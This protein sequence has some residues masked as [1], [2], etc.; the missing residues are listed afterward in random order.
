MHK[1][2]LENGKFKFVESYTGLDG[3][4]H[5]VSVTKNN[6]TRVTEKRAYEELQEKINKKLNVSVEYHTLGYYIDEFLKYKKSTITKNTYTSYNT[7]FKILNK[8]EN[9]KNINKKSM[10]LLLNKQR[11]KYSPSSLKLF[12]VN[13]NTLFKYI[14]EYHIPD[15]DVKLTFSLNKEE[16]AALKNKVKYIETNQISTV[17]ENIDKPIVK[18]FVTVQ[19]HTGLRVGELLALT[20]QDVDFEQKIIKITKTKQQ[21]G[22]LTAPKTLSS[23]REIE[24]SDVVLKILENNFTSDKFIF[25]IS[26]SNIHIHLKKINLSTHMF[27]HTHVALLIEKGVPIKIISE[28]LGHTD[29]QTTLNIYTHV[30][31]NMKMTLR[32]KLSELGTF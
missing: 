18:D 24:V 32:E 20:R 16:K 29:T 2:K 19:L 31:E 7:A 30:T 1:I 10:E 5:R 6:Q 8:T 15:F 21:D 9:I 26:L 22:T 4:R 12:K 11:S 25:N 27:R 13:Y 23:I 14:Q 3:K 28:R 17:L